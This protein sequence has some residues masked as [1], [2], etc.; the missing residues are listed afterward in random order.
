MIR[1]RL[2]P[3][4]ASFRAVARQLL[5]VDVPP[6][7]VAWDDGSGQLDLFASGGEAVPTGPGHAARAVRVSPAFLKEAELAACHSDPARWALLYRVVWR[8]AHGEPDL[9]AAAGDPDVTRLRVLRTAVRH[10][11]HRMHAFVRF[12]PAGHDGDREHML[13]W[14]EPEHDIL[15]LTAPFFARRFASLSWVIVTPR[16]I[17]AWDG[18]CVE[19]SARNPDEPFVLPAEDALD[20]L[21]RAYYAAIFNP[22]RAN[23]AL[24]AH[25]VPARFRS[26]MPETANVSALLERAPVNVAKMVGRVTSAAAPFLP[27]LTGDRVV[28]HAA[29]ALAV[30][31]C[32]G[33]AIHENATQAV[34][35]EGPLDAAI[36][37]VGE[38]PGDNEDRAGRAF[39]GPAGEVLDR[40][41]LAAKLP[42]ASVYLTNAVKHFK[43]EP[44]G[45]RRLHSRPNPVEVHACRGWLD[46]ELASVKPQVVVCL[47]ATAARALLGRNVRLSEVRGKVLDGAPWAAKLVVANHPSAIL[48]ADT[49]EH[50]EELRS[51]LVADL[52]LAAASID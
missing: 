22:A 20:D 30:Q 5:A 18:A 14:F 38:Q 36:A 32:A 34:F 43:W 40:A 46:A 19:L 47:G 39:I 4:F 52:A 2:Q 7:R 21:F 48:R 28:D 25:H 45:K 6:D 31:A 8:I 9:L 33:C 3:S 27:A 13:A 35:G 24:F 23:A 49:P 10:D 51:G 42:R 16:R 15:P 50:A 44:R 37:L 29:M 1:A 11:E 26:N 17:A 41:L 12:R